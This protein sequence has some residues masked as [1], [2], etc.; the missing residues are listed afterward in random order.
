MEM[1]EVPFKAW[2]LTPS[3]KPV[4]VDIVKTSTYL[5]TPY[6][7]LKTGRVVRATDIHESKSEA[8]AAG[9]NDCD[10]RQKELNKTRR[11]LEN[12]IAVLKQ[13]AASLPT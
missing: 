6:F 13:A 5:N 12:R 2:K 10:R 11:R 9:F 8:I 3:G 4:E 1:K 7:Q